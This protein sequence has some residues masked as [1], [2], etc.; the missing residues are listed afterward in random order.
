MDATQERDI[1]IVLAMSMLKALRVHNEHIT[2][3]AVAISAFVQALAAELG[4]AAL[5]RAV[6]DAGIAVAEVAGQ[7][8]GELLGQR[9]AA[10]DGLRML[11]E[12]GCHRCRRGERMRTIGPA[13]RL[14][15]LEREVVAA[16]HEGVLE[17]D[18]GG[19]VRMHVAAGH[20]AQLQAR[21]PMRYRN[22]L[23]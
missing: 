19:A 8:E 18:A 6:L 1:A 12:A 2:A 15:G 9:S 7:V 17:R 11:G 14:A 23:R 3:S 13:Q 22:W 16:G 20:T 10:G 5:R 21:G 4:Q